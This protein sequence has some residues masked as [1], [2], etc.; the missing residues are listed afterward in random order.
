MNLVAGLLYFLAALLLT[1]LAAWLFLSA[2]RRGRQEKLNL[3]LRALGV[4]DS[5]ASFVPDD[6]QLRNPFLRAVCYALWRS[7]VDAEPQVVARALWLV[8]MLVPFALLLLGVLW[9]GIA[10]IAIAVLIWVWLGRQ[11]ARRRALIVSQLP[12]FLES[13]IRVL[14]AGNSVEESFAGSSREAPEPVRGL[15]QAVGRQIRLGAPMEQVLAETADIYRIRDLK[16][17]ALASAINRKYGGSLRNVLKSLINA[18]RSR[19][20]ANRELRALT[21]ETRFSAFMMAIIPVSLSL[22]ILAQN[23]NYYADIWAQTSGRTM[24]LLSVFWQIAG[25]VVIWRMMQST[26]DTT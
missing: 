26:E 22:Y 8:L 4:D 25:I 12:E 1:A 7:G 10:L 20:V 16:V 23:P 3:R 21:A 15:F 14:S 2:G 9:G 24:V 5:S 17:L 6:G 11:A 13:V 19:D 18:V